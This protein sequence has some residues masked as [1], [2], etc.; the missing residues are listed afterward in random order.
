MPELAIS[1]ETVCELIEASRELAGHTDPQSSRKNRA[2]PTDDDT[3]GDESA[4]HMIEQVRDDP[5]RRQIAEI[6]GTLNIEEQV[7]LLAL[8][9]LGGGDY[10]IDE[11]DDALAEAR[12]RIA[13]RDADFLIG[14]MAMPDRLEAG[15]QAFE[16]TCDE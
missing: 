4:I 7:N 10:E 8:L 6:I 5:T 16:R 11:W 14:D 13:S 12:D 9:Y 1:T 15:L 2:A 3:D